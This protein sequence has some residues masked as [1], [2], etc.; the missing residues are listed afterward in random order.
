M[1]LLIC[2]VVTLCFYT[3]L[4]AWIRIAQGIYECIDFLTQRYMRRHQY[5][6]PTVPIFFEA[7]SSLGGV[8]WLGVRVTPVFR[9]K[10]ITDV[11]RRP[12]QLQ[13]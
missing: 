6:V 3:I 2:T 12:R 1:G 8:H 11:K 4:P 13:C 5:P 9:S 10:T 7:V